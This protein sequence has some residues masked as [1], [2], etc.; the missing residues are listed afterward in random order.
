MANKSGFDELLQA[1]QD[2]GMDVDRDTFA[3]GEGAPASAGAEQQDKD[4]GFKATKGGRGG[5]GRGQQRPG[6]GG[7]GDMASAFG[8]DPEALKEMGGGRG[9]GGR[10][11]N[12]GNDGSFFDTLASWTRKAQVFGIIALIVALAVAY[13]WFHPALNLQ[14]QNTWMFILVAAVV[15]FSGFR[16]AALRQD[17]KAK[18]AERDAS[19]ATTSKGQAKSRAGLYKT[20]SFIPMAVMAVF[21]IGM[22][23]SQSF[24]PGNAEKFANV[25]QTQNLDF[26]QD[27]Q[28]VNYKEI[29]VIDRDAAIILGD[30]KMGSIPEYVSQFEVDNLYSQINYKNDPVRVSPLNYADLFKWL[31]NRE[32]GIP[33]YALVNMTTQDTD[34]VRVA[35]LEGSDGQGIK[36]SQSEPL[37]RN[38]DRHVQLK[39]PFY[40]F[41]DFSFEID[42]K[43]HPWWICPTIKKTIGLFGGETIDRVVMCDAV[44]GET[45]D[46]AVDEVPTWV[47]RV[48][49]SELLLRQYNWYGAYNNGWINSWL[50]QQGVVKT[51]PGNDDQLGYNYIAKDGD[52]WVYSGVTSATADS[53][54][55]GF[56]LIN[57]RTG[58]SHFYGIA[59]ATELSAMQSAEGQVQ[60]LRYVA[61]FPILINVSNQPTY[62]MAL[63]DGAGTV[64]KFAMIDIKRYQNVAVGDT[65]SQCQKSYVSLLA[66]NG[67]NLSSGDGGGSKEAKGTISHMAQ[68]VVDGNSHF[69]VKLQGEKAV[70]DF[71]LPNLIEIVGYEKGDKITFTYVEGP[72]MNT[73]QAFG[74]LKDLKENG[75]AESDDDAAAV[76]DGAA[77]GE[78]QDGAEQQPEGEEQPQ[79]GGLKGLFS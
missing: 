27:I 7:W 54:I 61:T 51:T 42:E 73:V 76:T 65:V 67:V 79:E 43:G 71:A 31:T 26:A 47:D 14:S 34:I 20:L 77:D 59:G 32:Q 4:S 1:L 53:S 30:K 18:K 8:F 75:P 46:L 38:I 49:P 68:A 24:F 63:K 60:N 62:F 64:K 72:S 15:L 33:A 45:Q 37:A 29:P 23:L 41:A 78:Q 22:L 50:G 57:Q 11:G 25:L 10:G 52:V 16:A 48:Y 19:T 28:E 66:T 6:M 55:V 56:V 2:S 5:N 70:Y 36:Y 44:T 40:M 12:G 35:E 3:K 17:M 74:T 21:V 69:Y 9:N 39:Y 13:W 58:E